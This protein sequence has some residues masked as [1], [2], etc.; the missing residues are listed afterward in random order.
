MPKKVK[1]HK[2]NWVGSIG[3]TVL[4][5]SIN[6]HKIVRGLVPGKSKISPGNAGKLHCVK[7]YKPIYFV[8]NN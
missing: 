8:R 1:C 3:E 7:C 5:A 4:G 2:C 6:A